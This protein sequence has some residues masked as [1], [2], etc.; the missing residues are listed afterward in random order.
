[1]FVLAE[2]SCVRLRAVLYVLR[3]LW[4]DVYCLVVFVT[5]WRFSILR[6]VHLA[7]KEPAEMSLALL[8]PIYK[9]GDHSQ[10][11]NY[12]PI[13]VSSL[14][15]KLY[16]NCLG[17]G[18]YVAHTQYSHQHGDMFPRQAGF[19]PDRSTLH[20]MFV[21]QHLAHHALTTNRLMY[22]YDY[23]MAPQRG[24]PYGANLGSMGR[25]TGT[26][27]IRSECLSNITSWSRRKG[28]ENT[29]LPFIPE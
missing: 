27:S 15:H 5:T 4:C 25:N 28:I 7:G 29:T 19:L 6:A 3:A 17:S 16:A 14:L 23:I 10:E 2:L 21:V 20:N 9:R 13:V 22:D 8:N 26:W 11:V 18:V 12:R 1:M 24:R